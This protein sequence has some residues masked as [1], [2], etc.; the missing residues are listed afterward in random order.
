MFTHVFAMVDH[1]K[2][3]RL[4]FCIQRWEYN[5]YCSFYI[6]QSQIWDEFRICKFLVQVSNSGSEPV[7]CRNLPGKRTTEFEN[8]ASST[9]QR[10]NMLK[11][12][13]FSWYEWVVLHWFILKEHIVQ[14]ITWKRVLHEECFNIDP[15][16]PLW[17][18]IFHTKK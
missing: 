11:E 10:A 1:H 15:I 2:D 4:F 3:W 9:L 17:N 16:S 6:S 18:V 14:I 5:R 8:V 7:K 12:I 13:A